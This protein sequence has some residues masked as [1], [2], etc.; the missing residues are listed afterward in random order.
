MHQGLC[1][2]ILVC[3]GGVRAQCCSALVVSCASHKHQT[4]PFRILQAELRG[5]ILRSK[6][7]R[8]SD[9][10][11]GPSARLSLQLSNLPGSAMYTIA[12][13]PNCFSGECMTMCKETAMTGSKMSVQCFQVRYLDANTFYM[14]PYVWRALKCKLWLLLKLTAVQVAQHIQAVHP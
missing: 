10:A 9:C 11:E 5:Q 4:F 1:C 3:Q 8:N 2:G 12:S 6:V 14:I 7:N 13:R